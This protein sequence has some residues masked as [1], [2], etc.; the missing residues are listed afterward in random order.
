MSSSFAIAGRRL[1]PDMPPYIVAEMSA[2]HLQQL[3]RAL[4]IVEAAAA[5]GADAVKLQSYTADTITLDAHGR[6]FDIESGPWAGQTL[7]DLYRSAEMP[8]DWHEALFA[9]GAKLGIT[10]FSAPFDLTA[11]DLLERC[12]N[13]VYKIASFE[14]IDLPLV[15]A[16]AA[17]GKPLIMSTGNASL[18]EVGEALEAARHA[19]ARDI[20]ILHCISGYPTPFAEANLP[21]LQRLA[22]EFAVPVGLS[23]HTHGTA[24]PVAATALGAVLIEKHVT[25]A[26]ADGGPDAFFSLEPA[27]LRELVVSTKAAWEA[28]QDRG[29]APQHAE[30]E[31]RAYRRSLYAVADIA[32][33]EPLS[34]ANTRSIRPGFGLA[35]RH[36]PQLLGRRA[37]S[38]I[39][40]G[41]PLDWSLIEGGAVSAAAAE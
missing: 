25:L 7:H 20:L 36:L 18:A 1:G 31:N 35:P 15:A 40:R 32:A 41:T 12:G 21:R 10:V 16:C 6:G 24:V 9:H 39:A 13:P 38:A 23:D 5:A 8:W 19:G 34:H 29:L 17:T 2:N 33:G 37:A 4:Q 11:V 26:R 30:L 22:Q 27:E 3:P 14:L 28:C